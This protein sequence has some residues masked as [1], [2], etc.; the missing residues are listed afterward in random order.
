MNNHLNKAQVSQIALIASKKNETENYVAVNRSFAA[1]V[2]GG[3]LPGE[4]GKALSR[5]L[6]LWREHL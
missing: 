1:G 3:R 2:P 5:G 4:L 6:A